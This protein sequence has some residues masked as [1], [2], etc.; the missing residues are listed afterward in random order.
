MDFLRIVVPILAFLESVTKSVDDGHNVDVM[1]LDF[2]K[3]FDKVPH[4][5]LLMKLKSHGVNGNVYNWIQAWLR[6]QKQRECLNSCLSSW[7]DVTSGVPQGSV[8]CPILFLIFINDIDCRIVNLLM[9][10]ADDTKIFGTVDTERLQGI[11]IVYSCGPGTGRWS[12]MLVNV[13]SCIWVEVMGNIDV[14]W[15]DRKFRE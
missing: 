13:E 11:L 10:F 12:L 1:F 6:G 2:A 4:H 7:S 15:M 3:A 5:R 8:L 9:K 14:F